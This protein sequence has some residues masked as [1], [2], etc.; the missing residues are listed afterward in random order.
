MN[1]NGTVR[2]LISKVLNWRWMHASVGA[3][4]GFLTVTPIHSNGG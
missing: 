3:A 4:E 2:D 1:L